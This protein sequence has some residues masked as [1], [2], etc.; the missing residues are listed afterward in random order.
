MLVF[1]R[2]DST[3]VYDLMLSI[4]DLFYFSPTLAVGFNMFLEEPYWFEHHTK[5][6]YFS[7][8]IP[9][10]DFKNYSKANYIRNEGFGVAV[11][12]FSS[13]MYLTTP[14]N[15]FWKLMKSVTDSN[16]RLGISQ[17]FLIS[18]IFFT[19]QLTVL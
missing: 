18:I 6:R 17:S 11:D 5:P 3:E 2:E 1:H 9:D 19:H 16:R 7:V 13:V 10:T 15:V 14:Q 12:F 4:L 8:H